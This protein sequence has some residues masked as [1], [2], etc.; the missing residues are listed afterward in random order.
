MVA[1]GNEGGRGATREPRG[2]VVDQGGA[3]L[4][5]LAY[6]P[7]YL[8]DRFDFTNDR[9]EWRRLFGEFLG[10]FFLV[11]VAQAEGWSTPGSADTPSARLR[12]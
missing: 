12:S 10:T 9:N 5:A 6:P 7:T 3:V 4:G 1:D 2:R 8:R 11:L